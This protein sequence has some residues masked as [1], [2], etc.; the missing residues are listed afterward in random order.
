MYTVI[1]RFSKLFEKLDISA[2]IV[3]VC[4]CMPTNALWLCKQI[5]TKLVSSKVDFSLL[6]VTEL[7]SL[8]YLSIFTLQEE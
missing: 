6:F 1:I 2:I 3:T 7:K 5:K 8:L 4:S